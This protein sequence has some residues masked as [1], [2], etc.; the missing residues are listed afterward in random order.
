MLTSAATTALVVPD[1]S[2]V[3]S[4][5]DDQLLA[6]QAQVAAVRRRADAASATLAAEVARRSARDLGYSGL[7]Q[8]RG[9]RTAERL[10][11]SVTGLS[12]PEARAMITAG[13][14]LDAGDD[15]MLPVTTA[16]SSGEV[17]VGAT[18]A[19]RSALGEP[20][21]HVSADELG[22]AAQRVLDETGRMPPEQVARRARELRDEL[23]AAGVADRERAMR[24]RR[25]LKLTLQDDGMTRITGLLDPESAALVTDAID[26][27]TAPRRGGPRFV[28]EGEKTRASAIVDDSRATD[29][30]AIDALVEMV[31]IAAT[32]DDGRVFGT[33]KPAVRVHVSLTDLDARRGAAA[34]EGQTAAVSAETAERIGCASGFL[35]LLFD[36]SQPL[37]LGRSQRLYSARQRVMLA[38]MWGGCAIGGCDRP[39]SWTEAHH[40]DHWERDQ[41]RTDVRD[42][43]LLCRHHHMWVH[44]VGARI[45]RTGT[46]Y[47]LVVPGGAPVR[48]QSKN[49][50][51]R[52]MV[53]AA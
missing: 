21:E 30:I 42:G 22:A 6:R 25:F 36:G 23:D 51:R 40:I 28:D 16:L 52:R 4:L 29:Q 1:V 20:G 35:T 26:L 32:A 13:E 2:D 46:D 7:A 50:V 47:D 15:W 19:I 33:H 38:A 48:L 3:A 11:A 37:D 17:S 24:E 44:D 43:I 53:D 8:K 10:V 41:G 31:R 5:S 27:V 12:V 18:A 45:V 39:P 9:A 49:P 34:L 14:A